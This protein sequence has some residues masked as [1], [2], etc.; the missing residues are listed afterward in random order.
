MGIPLGIKR[1]V[2]V[3]QNLVRLGFG[4][5]CTARPGSRHIIIALKNAISR[6]SSHGAG[7]P[8]AVV[9]WLLGRGGGKGLVELEAL[10]VRNLKRFLRR[11]QVTGTPST[12]FPRILRGPILLI[13]RTTL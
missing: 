9:T 1:Y 7:Q 8:D 10:S 13:P 11:A 12:R 6:C 5:G 4:R 2:R 3:V